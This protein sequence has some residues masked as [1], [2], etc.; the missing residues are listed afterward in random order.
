MSYRNL[1]VKFVLSMCLLLG[2]SAAL[3]AQLTEGTIAV[4]VKDSSGAA[5]PS[6]TV[7]L[8]DLG[9]GSEVEEVTDNIG[10]AR[11]PHLAPG[12]Y[13]MNVNAKGFKSLVSDNLVVSVNVV[14]SLTVVLQIGSVTETI[15]VTPTPRWFKPKK[16]A[17]Q[18]L[19][20]PAKSP[21]Y[22]ST[23]ATSINSSPSSPA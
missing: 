4:T 14:N 15:E 18:T 19:S 16:A 3:S 21:T 1:I 5:V 7:K 22:P 20:P 17:S 2:L 13:R 10:Y 6:A 9:T 12:T 8:T 11:I 23:A